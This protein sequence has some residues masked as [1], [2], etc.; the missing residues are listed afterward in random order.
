MVDRQDIDALLIGGLYGELGSADAAR[1]QGHLDAHPADRA[2]LEQLA[3]ARELVRESRIVEVQPDPPQALSALLLQEAARRAPRAGATDSA[4]APQGEGWLARLRRS[5]LM[6]PAMAAAATL[7]LVVGVAGTMYLRRGDHFAAPV[8]SAVAPREAAATDAR[9]NSVGEAPAGEAATPAAPAIARRDAVAGEAA[10][11]APPPPPA[12]SASAA[13]G[14]TAVAAS[15]EE[16]PPAQGAGAY[17][18]DLETSSSAD[19]APETAKPAKVKAAESYR[20]DGKITPDAPRG[21]AVAAPPARLPQD[22]PVDRVEQQA[23]KRELD[24]AQLP[25]SPAGGAPSPRSPAVTAPAPTTAP[26][27]G[28]AP[29]AAPPPPPERSKLAADSAARSGAADAADD[30]LQIAEADSLWAREQHARLRA[31]V[32]SGNCRD[33]AVTAVILA[34]RAPAYYRQSVETD[35]DL[36]ACL[37]YINSERERAADRARA[38]PASK[39]AEPAPTAA[40]PVKAPPA[41]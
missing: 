5:L 9:A 18:V 15:R 22:L 31:Q 1:L 38:R 16:R 6:H 35:R 40:P 17:R 13:A 12:A 36:K 37:A 28:A 33:A 20:R 25:P 39:R 30:R 7:V 34:T 14:A 19:P 11:S 8:A 27:E 21:L 29:A 24:G 26:S 23:R 32:R 4:R 10:G 2:L 3:R 41:K